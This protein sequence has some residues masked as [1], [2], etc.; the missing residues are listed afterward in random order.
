VQ[1]RADES[2]GPGG[3]GGSSGGSLEALRSLVAA[4]FSPIRYLPR[5]AA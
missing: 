5:R 3:S 2:G 1:S 4:A